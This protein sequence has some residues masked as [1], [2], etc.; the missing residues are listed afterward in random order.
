MKKPAGKGMAI[1]GFVTGLIAIVCW[2]AMFG[3]TF[4]GAA[5]TLSL[6]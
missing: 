4:L 1:A 5:I 3:L 6:L 2:G